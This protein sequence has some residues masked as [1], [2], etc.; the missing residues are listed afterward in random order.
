MP[1]QIINIIMFI[2]VNDMSPPPMSNNLFKN[3]S[4]MQFI[5][6]VTWVD[7]FYDEHVF[8]F[9]IK[10]HFIFFIWKKTNLILNCL[11]EDSY[12]LPWLCV[13][14]GKSLNCNFFYKNIYE[15]CDA[16]P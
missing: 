12:R 2:C 15:K 4:K 16:T 7:L 11:K 13:K 14:V 1:Q 5:H 10:I 6:T 9:L 3:T 8:N